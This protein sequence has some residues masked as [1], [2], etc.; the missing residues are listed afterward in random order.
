MDG[1]TIFARVEFYKVLSHYFWMIKK[2]LGFCS[3]HLSYADKFVESAFHDIP[4]SHGLDILKSH[5][6]QISKMQKQIKACKRE[7]DDLSSKIKQSISY[8][9]EKEN[10]SIITIKPINSRD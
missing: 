4:V 1:K 3:R 2:L 10:E 8:C 9:K 5:R 7:I 6:E